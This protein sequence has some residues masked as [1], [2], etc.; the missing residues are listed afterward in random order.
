VLAS[1]EA[2]RSS[3]SLDALPLFSYEPREPPPPPAP[4]ELRTA[5]ITLDPD[6]MSPR[7][8]L[9]A[10]YKLRRLIDGGT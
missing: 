9:E 3:S 5:L 6:A 10:L 8:A 7:D 4:D 2:T 1:L